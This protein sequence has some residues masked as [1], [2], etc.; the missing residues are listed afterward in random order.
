[1]SGS[2]SAGQLF[3]ERLVVTASSI[4]PVNAST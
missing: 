1:M 3:G 2:I 4:H